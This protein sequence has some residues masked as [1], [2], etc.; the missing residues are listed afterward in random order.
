[1][2]SPLG[3]SPTAEARAARSEPVTS[4]EHVP[5][6]ALEH[7]R[8]PRIQLDPDRSTRTARDRSAQQG[9]ADAGERVEHELTGPTEELDDPGHEPRWL[10]RAVR[11]A[12]RVP[13]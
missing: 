7:R 2:R 5:D 3:T 8:P 9:A 11:L 10:V 13:K 1:M 6:D 12:R 4:A